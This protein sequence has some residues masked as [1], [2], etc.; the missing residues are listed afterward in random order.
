MK[1]ETITRLNQWAYTYINN[2]KKKKK[3]KKWALNCE[4]H[5]KKNPE[6]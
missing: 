3:K 4:K 6:W 1:K 5:N 2:P